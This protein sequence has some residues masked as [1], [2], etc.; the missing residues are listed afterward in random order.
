M[1]MP[2]R[3]LVISGI[4]FLQGCSNREQS[5][6]AWDV[7]QFRV[8]VF[9]RELPECKAR[10]G[11]CARFNA[12]YPVLESDLDP[13]VSQ[14]V[15]NAVI[16]AIVQQVTGKPI[17]FEGNWTLEDAVRHFFDLYYEANDKHAYYTTWEWTT[18]ADML[19]LSKKILSL[20]IENY[21][22][23]GGAHPN[24]YSVYLNYNL[25]TGKK[26]ELKD[27]VKDKKALEKLARS[28]FLKAKGIQDSKAG[29]G[30]DGVFQFPENFGITGEGLYFFYNPY[31]AGPYAAGSLDFVLPWKM[32]EGICTSPAF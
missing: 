6:E 30:S 29:I 17:A 8:E 7:P 13:R 18:S 14:V 5:T 2:C 25:E 9:S 20:G 4:L 15:N 21:N 32:L 27:L 28:A 19:F 16:A 24:T 23:S 26:I 22:Y 10:T 3:I 31:E 12:E 1:K 11:F